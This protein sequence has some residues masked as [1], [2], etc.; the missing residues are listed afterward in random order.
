MLITQVLTI[1]NHQYGTLSVEMLISRACWR[2]RNNRN[3]I[4]S[5]AAD[6]LDLATAWNV[7]EYDPKTISNA[8]NRTVK[9]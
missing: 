5:Q 3:D 9:T 6:A 7:K 1:I 4:R 2:G 8:T